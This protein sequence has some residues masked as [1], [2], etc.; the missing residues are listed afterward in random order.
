MG[1]LPMYCLNYSRKPSIR[2]ATMLYKRFSKLQIVLDCN[3]HFVNKI[4]KRINTFIPKALHSPA[5][6]ADKKLSFAT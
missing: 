1:F 3:S 6:K 2:L 5:G 4:Q